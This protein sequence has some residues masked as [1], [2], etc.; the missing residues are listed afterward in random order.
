M[1][2]FTEQELDEIKKLHPLTVPEKLKV[3]I[4]QCKRD[5]DRIR[6]LEGDIA[7]IRE[8]SHDKDRQISEADAEIERLKRMW[9][10]E[11]DVRD[12]WILKAA[13]MR[14]G[15]REFVKCG[16]CTRC[17]SCLEPPEYTNCDVKHKPDCRLATLL[18][19]E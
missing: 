17:P 19:E 9:A 7:K 18:K 4:S 8:E 11:I 5:Q 15:L 10:E 14:D 13:R 6:E 16:Y 1:M 2:A 3:A 12:K